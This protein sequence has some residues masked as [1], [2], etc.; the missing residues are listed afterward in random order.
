MSTRTAAIDAPYYAAL[1]RRVPYH[2]VAQPTLTCYLLL[3]QSSLLNRAPRL[4][5]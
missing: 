1:V 4:C 2:S 3:C 5:G